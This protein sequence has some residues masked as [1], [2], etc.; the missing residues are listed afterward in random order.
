MIEILL[1]VVV[2]AVVANIGYRY[3]GNIDIPNVGEEIVVTKVDPTPKTTLS[4][5]PKTNKTMTIEELNSM[6][7]EQMFEMA[8]QLNLEVYKSWTKTKL[9]SALATH[10]EL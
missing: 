6:T 2:V 8:T 7:K 3:F 5:Q 4:S 10:H 9:M 1:Y